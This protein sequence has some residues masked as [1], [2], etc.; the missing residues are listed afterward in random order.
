[1]ATKVFEVEEIELQDG[2]VVTIKP[3]TIKRL[4]KFMEVVSELDGQ[5]EEEE[6][7]IDLMVSA[8]AIAIEPSNAELANNREKLEDA[9]DVPTMWKIL[10]VAG[11]VKM[12]DPNLVAAG[13]AG[14]S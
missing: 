2:S 11:G 5:E 13:I 8:C 3:L 1:M 14:R 7:T 12:S 4:R 6:K 9:L 10:E